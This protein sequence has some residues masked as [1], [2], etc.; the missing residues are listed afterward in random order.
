MVI[1]SFLR[2]GLFPFQMVLSWL[3]LEVMLTTKWDDP[4]SKVK[5]LKILVGLLI[6]GF[7]GETTCIGD[8]YDSI[9]VMFICMFHLCLTIAMIL[10]MAEILHQ[11]IGSL[12]HYLQG[13]V[14]HT[15]CRISSINSIIHF[16]DVFC[17]AKTEAMIRHSDQIGT[18]PTVRGW[19]VSLCGSM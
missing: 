12:S 17:V 8:V 13:F 16:D 5:Q 15:W 2:I 6:L 1:E 9:F 4:P 11:L 10:L 14:H 18:I 7:H 3:F 19:G